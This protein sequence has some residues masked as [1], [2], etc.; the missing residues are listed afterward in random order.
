MIKQQSKKLEWKFL[1]D[2][3][4]YGSVAFESLI[5]CSPEDLF[6]IWRMKYY[7]DVMNELK[8]SQ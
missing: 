8:N 2:T 4:M 5:W 3:K 1:K 7:Q 6:S